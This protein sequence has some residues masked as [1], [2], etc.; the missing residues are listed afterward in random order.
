MKSTVEPAEGNKVKV[1]VEVDES[2][3]DGDVDAAFR[4]IAHEVRIP[5]FRPGKAP[6]RILEARIGT[7]AARAEAMQHAL[8][9]YYAQAVSGHDVDVIAPPEIDVT[10]GEDEGAVVFDAVVEVRPTAIVGGYASLRIT[11][12]RPSASEEEIDARVEHLR[13]QFATLADVDRPARDGDSVTID[14]SGTQDGEPR[15]G[16]TAEGYQYEVGAGSVVPEL[17]EQLRGAKVGDILTFTADHPDPDEDPVD[18]RVLVKEVREKVLPDLDDAFAAEA[19]EFDTVEELR[20]A[21]VEFA[22]RYNE[23]WLVA[24]YGYRTPAQVRADQCRLDPNA[25]ADLKLAA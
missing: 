15:D 21:L 13:Q 23:T 7:E 10:A 17:D 2:E 20:A 18:F 19:S 22:S 9:E 25:T 24:R 3:F 16:L 14:I 1:S 4:R 6:R 5:G 12:E 8:P 11:V